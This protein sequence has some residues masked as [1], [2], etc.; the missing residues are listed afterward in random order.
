MLREPQVARFWDENAS[1]WSAA[2]ESGQDILREAFH[3][4]AFVR[5]LGPVR[6]KRVLDAGCGE[7]H[8]TRKLAAAGAR[9]V[10]VDLSEKM[11]AV[12]TRAEAERPR[13]VRYL[14]ASYTRLGVLG[15]DRFDLVCAFMSLMD[16][17]ELDKAFRAFRRVLRPGGA[18]VFAV[19]HPCFAMASLGWWN[20]APDG[21]PRLQ[22]ARYFSETPRLSRWRFP[23]MGEATFA[24]PRFPRTLS[25]Y[26]QSLTD[27]GFQP[28]ALG[29]PRPTA[30]ACRRYPELLP[31]RE[32]AAA[33]LHVR[34]SLPRR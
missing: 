33:F 4:R 29:E 32:Q 34:A 13:G 19:L 1:A 21:I 14:K 12:A 28:D 5:F 7:G 20:G 31:W 9:V 6:G 26:V 30:A 15:D 3:E 11:L 23:G 8:L 24:V 18:L 25:R 27:A 16:G 22:V 17:P 10:G 2:L